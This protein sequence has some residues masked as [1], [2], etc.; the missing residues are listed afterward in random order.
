MLHAIIAGG[1][2]AQAN[3]QSVAFMSAPL[4]QHPSSETAAPVAPQSGKLIPAAS[5]PGNS[6]ASIAAVNR[7]AIIF[8]KIAIEFRGRFYSRV[9][10][11][12]KSDPSPSGKF[13]AFLRSA[14][15]VLAH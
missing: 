1:A 7:P 10:G 13:S 2:A 12:Q 3:E 6:V 4:P 14:P 5:A 15:T 11:S 8:W 9:T